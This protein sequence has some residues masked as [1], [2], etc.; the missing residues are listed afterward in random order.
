[1]SRYQTFLIVVLLI[2]SSCTQD[3]QDPDSKFDASEDIEGNLLIINRLNGPILLYTSESESPLKEIGAKEDFTVNISSDG[4]TPTSLQIW[5]KSQVS[6]PLEPDIEKIYK[7]WNIVLSNNSS[8]TDQVVWVISSGSAS[9]AVG[10]LSFYYPSMDF[11][12]NMVIYDASIYLNSKDGKKITSVNPGIENKIVGLDFGYYYLFYKYSYENNSQSETVGWIELDSLGNSLSTLVNAG[13]SIQNIEVPIYSLSDIGKFGYLNV[14]NQSLYDVKIFTQNEIQIEDIVVTNQST[15]GLSI[16]ESNGGS[17]NY[18]LPQNN[19][20]LT[21]KNLITGE[22]VDS[23]ENISVIE[24]YSSSWTISETIPYRNITISNNL[25]EPVTIHNEENND[26]LG[27]YIVPGENMSYLIADSLTSLVARN[28]ASTRETF[29]FGSDS[30]WNISSLNANFYLKITDSASIHGMTFN[31]AEFTLSWEFG[32]STDYLTYQL[33]NAEY[34]P[35]SNLNVTDSLFNLFT[36]EYLDDSKNEE[37]YVFRLNSNSIDGVEYGWQEVA[38]KIDAVQPNGLYIYPRQQIITNNSEF[39]FDIMLEEVE[40]VRSIY[41]EL[42]YDKEVLSIDPDSVQLGT[43]FSDCE[44]SLLLMNDNPDQFGI[45]KINI[46]FLGELCLGFEGSGNLV[47][48][49]GKPFQLPVHNESLLK[50]NN[51]SSFRDVNNNEIN[52]SN[53]NAS[54]SHVARVVFP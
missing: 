14:I 28:L 7:E 52:I 31:N 46:S 27:L 43:D 49:Q 5:K 23:R 9:P 29:Q 32:S 30:I 19:Y 50:I 12:G 20:M 10:Q 53:I 42:E 17:Y 48:V 11:M 38:F 35:Y 34:P 3:G 41:V 1:M 25:L 51:N 16:I 8:K 45:L 33:L 47:S 54:Q 40:N 21:A 15:Y 18:L 4:S 6:D 26:Y 44:G 36:F 24:L 13:N 22:I 37:S 39:D 2:L